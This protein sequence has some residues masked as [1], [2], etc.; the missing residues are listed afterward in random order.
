MRLDSLTL[1][2]IFTGFN[3]LIW[4]GAYW[5]SFVVMLC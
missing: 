1:D 2:Y 3:G 4:C 5:V